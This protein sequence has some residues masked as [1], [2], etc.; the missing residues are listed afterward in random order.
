MMAL[1]HRLT[2]LA[3]ATVGDDGRAVSIVAY[4]VLRSE[5]RGQVDEALHAQ[6]EQ[7]RETSRAHS[8]RAAFPLPPA[9]NGGPYGP[10]Q[11]IDFTAGCC[12]PPR[13]PGR[14][15][16]R[17]TSRSPRGSGA[18]C[19]ATPCQRRPPARADGGRRRRPRGAVRPQPAQRRHDAVAAEDP[20]RAAVRRPARAG[21]RIRRLFG[22]QVIQPVTDLT[23]ATK[24]ITQTEDLGRRIEVPGD[25]EVGRMAAR[26]NPMLDTLEGSRRALDHSV[27]AQRQLVADASHELR[28]PVTSLRT[29]IEVLLA[30]GELPEDDRRRLLEDVRAETE[31]LSS[32]ITDVIKLARGDEPLSGA[33]E[34]QL[35]AIVAEAV[36]R[37]QR[38]RPTVT[39]ATELKPTVVEGLP[40][41][42]GRAVGNLLDNA[43]KYS[44]DGHRRRGRPARWRAQRARP[45]PGH[46]RRR[47]PA[48]LRPLL[49]SVTARGAPRLRASGL[50]SCA[51][52]P[53]RTVVGIS[54]HEGAGGG[55]RFVLALP[56]L[57]SAPARRRRSRT[58]CLTGG[59]LTTAS[60]S[61]SAARARSASRRRPR[62]RTRG[63]RRRRRRA[64]RRSPRRGV[65]PASRA[66]AKTSLQQQP[67][68]PAA[69]QRR[70]DEQPFELPFGRRHDDPLGEAG[71]RAAGRSRRARAAARSRRR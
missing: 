57:A 71:A 32:L 2:I 29:N 49:P 21:G 44:P 46:S 62:G 34:V 68:D 1:R 12:S 52:S 55:S 7:V 10:V 43:A 16:R 45:R 65:T 69:H 33:V 58:T 53:R 47:P 9:R 6:L 18:R 50:R 5:L 20:A 41:R 54:V 11:M 26:F 14:P 48:R 38:R 25:D 19:C 66:R 63:A 64:A 27:H 3:A 67:A 36:A 60:A 35:D 28:T 56:V 31:E 8:A 39:F 59:R 37:A 15:D 70:L 51:R 4:V 24:H 42:L 61:P 23:A 30:G 40:D 13:R 22:R 17:S